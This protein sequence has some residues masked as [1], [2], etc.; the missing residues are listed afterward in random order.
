M[1]WSLKVEAF[2]QIALQVLVLLAPIHFRSQVGV[3]QFVAV[4]LIFYCVARLANLVGPAMLPIHESR[5]SRI[6]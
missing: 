1:M 4:A 3:P 5:V 2:L 6:P